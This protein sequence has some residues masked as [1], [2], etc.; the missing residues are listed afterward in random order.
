MK[1]IL[2]IFGTRPEAIKLAPVISELKKVKDYKVILGSTGQHHQMLNQ[3]L[4]LFKLKVDFDLH[5]MKPNQSLFDITSNSLK[6]FEHILLKI[7]PN[8]VIVQ[9]DTTTAFT[10]A[11][12]AFYAN[13][14]VAHVEAGLRSYNIFSPYPEEA[15]RRFISVLANYNFVPTLESKINL[16]NEGVSSKKVFVTGNTIVDAVNQVK[17]QLRRKSIKAKVLESLNTFSPNGLFHKKFILITLHRR[18]KFGEE[19]RDILNTLHQI[20]RAYPNYNF[21]YPV[22]LNPNVQN[23]VHQT[24]K[25][26]SNFILVPPLDYLSFSL[27]MKECYFIISDSGGIQEECYSFK[28]PIIVLRDVTERNEAIKAGYSFLVGSNRELII[29]KFDEIDQK[30]KRGPNFFN[31]KNPFGDGKAAAR[32]KNILL[33]HLK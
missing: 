17:K 6:N 28:K 31:Q 22:H 16:L 26:L 33:N 32:I 21:I 4:D 27:L 11:L 2:I 14:P 9:G 1:K 12:A 19:F 18:E 25:G 13:I 8:L 20:S 15:N 10:S 29:A 7:E 24:L 3:V 30:L 23:P 5:L